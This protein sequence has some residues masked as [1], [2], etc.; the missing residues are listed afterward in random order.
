MASDP[1]AVTRLYEQ[2]PLE[3]MTQVSDSYMAWYVDRV[4]RQLDDT[5]AGLRTELRENDAKEASYCPTPREQEAIERLKRRGLSA[6]DRLD[7][8]ADQ[9]ADLIPLS[10]RRLDHLERTGPAPKD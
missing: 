8:I 10:M 5:T 2:I 4:T 7:R 6:M 9:G 3:S 1:A